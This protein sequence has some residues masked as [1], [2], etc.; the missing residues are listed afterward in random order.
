MIGVMSLMLREVMG[1]L[2]AAFFLAVMLMPGVLLTKYLARGISFERRG[3]GVLHSIYLV[4][5]ALLVE[6]LAIIFVYINL[7]GLEAHKQ[8]DGAM[9]VNPFFIW[10]VLAALLSIE[11]LLR[12]QLFAPPAPA[13]F[14]TFLSERVK[15]SLEIDRIA[16]IESRDYEVVVVLTSGESHRTRMNISQW[17]AVLDERFV[18]VHRAF[19]VA[20][21]HVTAFDAQK[22]QVAGRTIEISR[23]YRDTAIG[24]LGK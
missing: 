6:Y 20:R 16:Y 18:R 23:K 10:F 7:Y 17:E 24:R 1:S 19:I 8:I 2:E 4:V 22:A 21:A 12:T 5:I 15:I 3:Q 13:R 14:V 11:W 9:V